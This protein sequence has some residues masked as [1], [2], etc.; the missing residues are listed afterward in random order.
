[1]NTIQTLHDDALSHHR[2][3]RLDVAESLY[4]AILA[5]NADH[6]DAHHNLGIIEFQSQ[7]IESGLTHLRRAVGLE[8]RKG[9]YWISLANNLVTAEQFDEAEFTLQQINKIGLK[10]PSVRLLQKKIDKNKSKL[11]PAKKGMSFKEQKKVIALLEKRLFIEAETAAR[12]LTLRYPQE[13]FGWKATGT[14]LFKRGLFEDSLTFLLKAVQLAP[15]DAECLNNL[16]NTLHNL[17][18]PNEALDC[19]KRALEINPDYAAAHN[20]IGVTLESLNRID[21]AIASYRRALALDPSLADAFSNLG[22]ALRKIQRIP[23]ALA[24]LKTALEVDPNNAK[25]HN[26]IGAI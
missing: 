11:S 4:R 6:A 15:Q 12:Q 16:G 23:E 24:C 9:G 19:Y 21:E 10:T 14:L 25:I 7:R 26:N 13:A 20:S 1:M 8:P 18:R 17:N 3:G 5:L 2:A 22:V